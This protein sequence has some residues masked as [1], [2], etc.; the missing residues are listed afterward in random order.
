M[1]MKKTKIVKSREGIIKNKE[2]HT[3]YIEI[4]KRKRAIAIVAVNF[5]EFGRLFK[6]CRDKAYYKIYGYNSFVAFLRSPE[7]NFNYKTVTSFIRIYELYVL[8]LKLNP[9]FLALVGHAKLQVLS[10]VVEEDPERWL[11]KA[12]GLTMLKLTKEVR[13]YQK[14]I[15][16]IYREV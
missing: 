5:L 15:K 3:N 13:V 11:S 10:P 16:E 8:R 12:K 1:K 7:I 9:E 6:N 14:E 2:A 4:R